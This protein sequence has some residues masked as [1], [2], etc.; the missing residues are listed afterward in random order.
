MEPT[1][2]IY[3][4][5]KGVGWQATNCKKTWLAETRDHVRVIVIEIS[6]APSKGTYYMRIPKS[7]GPKDYWFDD[8]DIKI[9]EHISKFPWPWIKFNGNV[10]P[11]VRY[12]ILEAL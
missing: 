1:D 11:E 3:Q 7:P 5:V 8:V 12:F 9:V 6:G 2:P 10:E 4:Y